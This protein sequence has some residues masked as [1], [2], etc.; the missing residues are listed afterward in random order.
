M[1]GERYDIE[2]RILVNGDI[3][4]VH[5]R[6][7]LKFD[8][9]G[10]PISGIGIVQDITER[11]EIE[12]RVR[13]LDVL[14]SKF[15]STLTHVTRTPLEHIR[16]SIT[17]ILS[18]EH[19]EV[20]GHHRPL[21]IEIQNSTQQIISLITTMN[22][23]LDIER[24]TITLDKVHTSFGSLTNSVIKT[25]E[26]HFNIK[27][28]N[29]TKDIREGLPNILLDRKY[30]R[31]AIDSLTENALHYT[32]EGGSVDF[33]ISKTK[34]NLRLTVKDTGI[35]IPNAEQSKIFERFFRASNANSMHPDGV[36][37]GLYLAKHIIEKHGGT[38]GFEST[39][40]KGSSFWIELPI[41]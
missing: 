30:L 37:L 32:K 28:I 41:K 2:H 39:E 23:V 7:V 15:I 20:H 4:W 21:L 13:E 8:T 11:K 35:G 1:K 31:I 26:T 29:V 10:K 12:K 17:S 18:E 22:T 25:H 40:G 6:A 34:G 33:K 14:K 16:L 38:L 3:K 19:G 24:N 36:G 5:E 9:D 27:N